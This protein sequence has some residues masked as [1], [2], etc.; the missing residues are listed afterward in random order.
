MAK[1]PFNIPNILES[2]RADVR[3]GHIS[4]RDAAIELHSAGW[5]NYIGEKAA[6]RLLREDGEVCHSSGW[7]RVGDR[8]TA[9]DK[10]GQTGHYQL[11]SVTPKHDNL[12][13]VLRA[14]GPTL[15][16]LR[17]EVELHNQ[18]NRLWP[19]PADA[20][21][22]MEVEAAWFFERKITLMGGSDDV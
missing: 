11:E 10:L 22:T 12:Y 5:V 9:R 20:L 4:L 2:L 17:R 16:R 3:A 14:V 1:K 8:F 19:M 18:H 7:L 21:D 15:D 6:L 13:A